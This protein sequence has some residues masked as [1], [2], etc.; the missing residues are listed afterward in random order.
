MAGTILHYFNTLFESSNLSTQTIEAALGGVE[1]S[2]K[3]N[4]ND[5]LL[6]PFS[7]EKIRVA[8]FQLNPSKAPGPD[9]FTMF[10][11]SKSM[12][13]GRR[14][15]RLITDNVRIGFECMHWIRHHNKRKIG[16]AALKLDMSKAYYRVEWNYLESIM[17]KMGFHLRWVNLIMRCVTSVSYSFRV[18]Q[19]IFGEVKP[20]RGLRQGDPLSPYLFAICAQG[21][22]AIFHQATT[23]KLFRGVKIA[24]NFP[25]VSHL[26][27][28]DDS[29]IFFR[30]TVQECLQVKGCLQRYKRAQFSSLRDRVFKR[31]ND[32]LF[33]FY[34]IEKH[35]AN[36]WWRNSLGKRSMHW[37][38]WTSLCK[39]KQLGGL[40]FW[41]MIEFNKAL[42]AKQ[43]WRVIQFHNSLLA[44]ILKARYFKF[45]N[46]MDAPRGSNPSYIWQS[47]IWGREIIA[48][49]IQWRVGDDKNIAAFK[50]AWIPGLGLGKS[51]M[52]GGEMHDKKVAEFIGP[53]GC[54]KVGDLQMCFPTF[55]VEQILNIPLNSG[56]II[57][58]R[59]WK[60]DSKDRWAYSVY[61]EFIV[62]HKV[63]T[64]S[65]SSDGV[66]IQLRWVKPRQGQFLLDVDAAVDEVR[67][68]FWLGAI[69]R[70]HR[71][72]SIGA[73]ARKIRSPGSVFGG[74]IR[75]V[76]HGLLFS[77]RFNLSKVEVFS[78]SINVVQSVYSS[79]DCL[80]PDG[81]VI[82]Q[83]K[84]LLMGDIFIGV[85][86]V[87]RQAN[88]VAHALAKFSCFY[89]QSI[90]WI[91]ASCFPSWLQEVVSSDIF[92]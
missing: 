15:G 87:R 9:G 60:W 14:G 1:V 73:S 44:R 19:S 63:L 8:A 71:G 32:P 85:S 83:V 18:N 31:I 16:Y 82:D 53:N 25:M 57:D 59:F 5:V 12:V 11:F 50:D 46:I 74:E 30:A 89:S 81:V 23:N 45:S 29:I 33:N 43:V 65:S 88:S 68:I 39:P 41:R 90:D 42:L 67:G 21:L 4:V 52:V 47:I 61:S 3:N 54:W 66:D 24:N 76:L 17:L 86:H 64:T 40:G 78:D 77:K 36:F 35:C 92:S 10:F 72:I 51:T 38:R 70:D 27:F 13:L 26:F 84:Y 79:A 62:A 48:K 37:A 55:E 34:E 69:I 80:G 58:R 49:G 2:V 91:D 22:S 56:G 6:V 20:K 28:A 75:V 7:S